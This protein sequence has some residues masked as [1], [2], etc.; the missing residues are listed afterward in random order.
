MSEET[1]KCAEELQGENND[2]QAAKKQSKTGKGVTLPLAGNNENHSCCEETERYATS[3][4]KWQDSSS[5]SE[6]GCDGHKR[7][8][9]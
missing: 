2:K 7:P 8:N 5:M 9:R 1:N 3:R 6:Q 4:H